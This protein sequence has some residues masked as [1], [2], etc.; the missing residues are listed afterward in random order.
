ML[1]SLEAGYIELNIYIYGKGFC[2]LVKRLKLFATMDKTPKKSV[3][4]PR[5]T[6]KNQPDA[7]PEL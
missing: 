5:P 1:V 4:P 6:S 7:R 3:F 2:N